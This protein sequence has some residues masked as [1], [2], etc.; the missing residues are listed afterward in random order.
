[1]SVVQIKV[2]YSYYSTERVTPIF[3]SEEELLELNY[4]AFKRKIV[5]DIPHLGKTTDVETLRLTVMDQGYHVDISSA[6]FQHQIKGILEKDSTK[7]IE[8][9]ALVFQ[10]PGVASPPRK[11]VSVT[12]SSPVSKKKLPFTRDF[13][14]SHRTAQ[15]F[16][17]D[18][19]EEGKKCS[20]PFERFMKKA[21]SDIER[22]KSELHKLEMEEKEISLKILKVQSSPSDG[23]MC[24]NCHLRLGHTARNCA[25][26]KCMSVFNC[27]EEKLHPGELNNR[28]RRLAINKLTSEIS[29]ME[30]ETQLKKDTARKINQSLSQ[31]IEQTILEENAGAY[32]SSGGLRN[33]SLLRKHATETNKSFSSSD[34]AFRC[35]PATKEEEQEQLN[36]VLKQ[37]LIESGMGANA[38]QLSNPSSSLPYHHSSYHGALYMPFSP[39]MVMVPPPARLDASY[40]SQTS[41]SPQEGIFTHSTPKPPMQCFQHSLAETDTSNS[42]LHTAAGPEMLTEDETAK[43]TAHL[44]LSLNSKNIENNTF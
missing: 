18:K 10:S 44:L 4:D 5:N 25:Y 41:P 35:R 1:M 27:G 39:G 8:V 3:L 36:M 32:T 7:A 21:E 12:L 38:Q 6:Y 31:Q 43:E 40:Q 20:T 29:K 2:V 14:A 30:R 16:E 34:L 19:P 15:D 13:T 37:S 24:R 23:N 26:G 42:S 28:G 22:K 17:L 33:W 11:K 9:K